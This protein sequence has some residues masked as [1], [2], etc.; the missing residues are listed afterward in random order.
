MARN[1]VGF[2]WTL[3]VPWAGFISLP[4]EIDEAAKVSRTIRYQRDLIRR[5]AKDEGYRLIYEEVFLEI[6][7]DRGSDLILEPLRKVKKICHDQDAILLFVDFWGVQRWRAHGGL[8]VGWPSRYRDAEH[9][10]A[11]D[12]DGSRV[13]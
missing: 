7:P 2:Y 3:P 6:E 12:S 5:Y 11:R 9:C 13:F 8:E 1:A 4:N 10:S